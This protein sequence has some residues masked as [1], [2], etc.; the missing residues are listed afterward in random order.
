MDWPDIKIGDRLIIDLPIYRKWWQVWR[1]RVTGYKKWSL[2]V[3][4]A[5]MQSLYDEEERYRRMVREL[6]PA[7]DMARQ[8]GA[9]VGKLL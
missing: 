6:R 3:T 4:E 8:A 7:F 2:A 5:R 9:D 1:P